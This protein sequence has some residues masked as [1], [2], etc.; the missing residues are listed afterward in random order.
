MTAMATEQSP[1][2]H[3]AAAI[4]DFLGSDEAAERD[5]VGVVEI[6]R[7]IG[8][9]KSQVSRA[10][11][12]LE[13]TGLVQRDPDTRG[14]RLGWRI[15]TLAANTSR[16]RLLAETPPVLR[17]LVAATGERA[18]LSVLSDD[19]ALT[20][21]SHSPMRSLQAGGWVGRSTPLHN[22]SSGRVL[23]FDHSE[24]DVRQLFADTP[25]TATGPR[26][27][28]DVDDLLTRLARDRKRGYSLVD[29]EFEQGLVAAAAP[30][31]DFRG[32][33]FAA[34]NVSAPKF[35]MKDRL[36]AAGRAVAAAA[37][38][39]SRAMAGVRAETT[40]SP[41]GRSARRR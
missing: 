11:R 40:S 34:L 5:G 4:L 32:R 1:S 7:A 12:V 10:L 3:R 22:T 31:R 27:P 35:R 14:Y 15:F 9:E 25:F 26:A 8:R 21:L 18:H 33:V 41:P 23:L 39:I 38:P 29:E 28:R 20:L 16:Q 36:D 37:A 30:I 19:S 2:V 6:A 24:D 17:R 13:Q